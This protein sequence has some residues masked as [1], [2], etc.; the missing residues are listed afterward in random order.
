MSETRLLDTGKFILKE[1]SKK[2]DEAA[3]LMYDR[4][5]IMIKIANNQPTI[6]QSWTSYTI[7]LYLVK[8]KR[9]FEL[10]VSIPKPED[11]IKV[12]NELPNF[13]HLVRES[14]MYAPLPEPQDVKSLDRIFDDNVLTCMRSPARVAELMINSALNE[15]A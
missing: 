4:E 12:V 2:F 7:N 6:I 15:G 13:A 1:L 11:A 3:V 9:V 8:D 5:S 10:E 14:E